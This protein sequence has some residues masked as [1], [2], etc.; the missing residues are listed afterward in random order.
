MELA[1]FR[2][3]IHISIAGDGARL[4]S[5]HLDEM[6]AEHQHLIAPGLGITSGAVV[7]GAV[8]W[9]SC[10]SHPLQAQTIY[11]FI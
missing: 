5:R 8:R 2:R 1:R 3:G 7:D 4:V 9:P 10:R 11:L 6:N